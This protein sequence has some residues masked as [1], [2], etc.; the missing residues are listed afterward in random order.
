MIQAEFSNLEAG[1]KW[2][3]A[4]DQSVTLAIFK[5][6][7]DLVEDDGAGGSLVKDAEIE[8]FEAQYL[9]R[10]SDQ[11][12]V[13]AGYTYL[14]GEDKKNKRPG[15]LPKSSFSIWNSY[16]LTEKIGSWPRCNLSG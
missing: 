1:I 10:I 12:T 9:G 5:I 3:L 15:E 2:D 7:Q 16:Q 6:D 13:S 14:T 8:G 11:W 4:D